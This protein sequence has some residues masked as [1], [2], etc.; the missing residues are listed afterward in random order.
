MRHRIEGQGQHADP[1]AE[2]F[3]Q[4]LRPVGQLFAHHQVVLILGQRFDDGVG[5]ARRQIVVQRRMADDLAVL[6]SDDCV[7]AGRRHQRARVG[8][9]GV[10]R[11]VVEQQRLDQR[12]AHAGR[13]F[14]QFGVLACFD[15]V[16]GRG[17]HLGQHVGRHADRVGHELA[18]H[19]VAGNQAPQAAIDHDRHAHRGAHVHVLEVLDVHRRDAA[20]Q[21]EAHVERRRAGRAEQRHGVVVHVGDQAQRI[22]GVQAARLGRDV[23][24]RVALAE[25]GHQIVA[26]AFGDH[27]AAV[28]G[29]EAVGHHAVEAGEFA[30]LAHGGVEQAVDGLLAPHAVDR[31]VGTDRELRYFVG[32]GFAGLEFGHDAAIGGVHHAVE[33][34]RADRHCGHDRG[35][36]VVIEVE[37]AVGHRV[38]CGD[39]QRHGGAGLAEHRDQAEQ[40]G[41][42]R[43]PAGQMAGFIEEQ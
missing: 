15:A 12:G 18:R 28:V 39:R 32:G 9:E 38:D 4:G 3:V 33:V 22:E 1:F 20:Q 7:G 40:R 8:A 14:G 37:D 13:L 10:E 11:V 6:G 21:G 29:A 23:A 25:V 30:H 31:A 16:D 41:R 36:I 35:G 5:Q 34:D 26:A 24:G 43:A 2:P 17:H 27:I 19:V 42:I